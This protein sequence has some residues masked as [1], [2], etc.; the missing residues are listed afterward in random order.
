MPMIQVP[1]K[2]GFASK[3]NWTQVLG[4]VASLVTAYGVSLPPELVPALLVAVQGV[5]SLV[6]ITMRMWFT[7][8]IMQGS[9]R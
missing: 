1:V 5:T 4:T 9:V 7:K 3:I 2:S 6:T 8:S